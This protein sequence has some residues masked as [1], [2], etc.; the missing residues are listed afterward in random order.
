MAL[1]VAG[2][3]LALLPSC[4]GAQG[5]RTVDVARMVRD[6]MPLKVR[7]AYGAGS[8]TLRAADAPYLYRMQLRYADGRGTV[9]SQYDT[10]ARE[11]RLGLEVQNANW[12]GGKARESGE[13]TLGLTRTVPLDLVIDLGATQST[14]DLGGFRLR[15]LVVHAGASETTVRFD[16]PTPQ[17]MDRIEVDAGAAAFHAAGLANTGVARLSVMGGLGL[18]DLDF[19]GAWRRDV[20]LDLTLAVGGGEITIPPDVGVRLS[21]EKTLGSYDF[22]GMT[23]VGSNAWETSGFSAARKK[24]VIRAKTTVG[25]L[26]II[27]R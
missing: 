7:V 27:R 24:L 1:G 18:V 6:T 11:L 26:K 17:P 13:L 10:I 9:L 25:T 14:V 3:I 19:R 16:Q 22:E 2:A 8:L 4:A 5:W 20:E 23:R 12:S 21:G 15:S